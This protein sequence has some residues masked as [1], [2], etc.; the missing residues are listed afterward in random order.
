MFLSPFSCGLAFWFD[1]CGLVF[2]PC[3]LSSHSLCFFSSHPLLVYSRSSNSVVG[4]FIGSFSID[5]YEG[6]MCSILGCG[7]LLVLPCLCVFVFLHIGMTRIMFLSL[8][9]LI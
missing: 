8:I 5:L 3:S 2:D 4:N 6:T 1:S 7:F 9:R